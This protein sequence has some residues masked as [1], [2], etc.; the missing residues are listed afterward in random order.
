MYAGKSKHRETVWRSS[1][2]Q[3]QRTEVWEEQER[4][5][6]KGCLRAAAPSWLDSSSQLSEVKTLRDPSP[7]KETDG[8]RG[9]TGPQPP[10]TQA[11][12]P[13]GHPKGRSRPR[14]R[15]SVGPHDVSMLNRTSAAGLTLQDLLSLSSRGRRRWWN[16][17]SI[18]SSY[19]TN[20]SQ[21]IVSSAKIP[22]TLWLILSGSKEQN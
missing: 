12:K 3:P 10:R 9:Q 14:S 11:Q 1:P 13:V 7:R 4:C 2:S 18:L 5:R 15:R 20:F 22:L 19:K 8:K 21:V 17:P 6:Y 16:K